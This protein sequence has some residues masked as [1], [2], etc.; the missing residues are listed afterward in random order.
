MIAFLV[1][2]FTSTVISLS[3]DLDSTTQRPTK[4]LGTTSRRDEVLKSTKFT[5]T[6]TT[7]T[8]S[9]PEEKDNLI[10]GLEPGEF[11]GGITLLVLAF[12]CVMLCSYLCKEKKDENNVSTT[13]KVPDTNPDTTNENQNS[14]QN[15]TAIEMT[16]VVV[17]ETNEIRSENLSQHDRDGAYSNQVS[18]E[19]DKTKA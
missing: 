2:I 12:F 14:G 1:I 9:N 13:G 10:A 5:T 19:V 15:N 4:D 18:R 7:V 11:Y 6:I 16:A 8:Q 17:R 3:T